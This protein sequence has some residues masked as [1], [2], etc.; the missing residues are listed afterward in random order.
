[1]ST[2]AAVTDA[3]FHDRVLTASGTTLVEFWAPWCPPCRAL[4][5]ILEQLAAEHPDAID[6]VKI[7]ADENPVSA[8]TYRAMALPVIKVFRD[9]EVVKTIIGAKPKPALERDLA[10]SSRW[11]RLR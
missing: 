9:G 1:M 8:A 10:P 4:S 5:P 11:T 2:L 3:T 6:I 7:N